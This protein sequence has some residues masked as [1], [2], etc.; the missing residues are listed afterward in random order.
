MTI[1]AI[2]SAWRL[3]SPHFFFRISH[4][5]CLNHIV[6]PIT[7]LRYH[8]EN[9]EKALLQRSAKMLNFFVLLCFKR[10]RLAARST[11]G[12]HLCNLRRPFTRH[13]PFRM[14]SDDVAIHDNPDELSRLHWDTDRYST[15]NIPLSYQAIRI[16]TQSFMLRPSQD[17]K[18]L[19]KQQSY[20]IT[21]P[22]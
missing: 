6:H 14:H 4:L 22:E 9:T 1:E 20:A 18:G 12:R 10:W 13:D 3:T 17:L 21:L 19:G 16:Q 8:W 5:I 11:S 15:Q 7:P 2:E